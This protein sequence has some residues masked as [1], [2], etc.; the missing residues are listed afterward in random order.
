MADWYSNFQAIPDCSVWHSNLL[1]IVGPSGVGKS[2]IANTVINISKKFV[3]LTNHTTRPPRKTDN[4]EQFRYL[5]TSSFDQLLKH[6][7]F[8]LA[9]LA[10]QPHYGYG[11]NEL[12]TVISKDK[13]AILMFRHSGIK[14]L[15]SQK[16]KAPT[17]FLEGDPDFIATHSLNELKKQTP[18]DTKK[19]I[20]SNRLLQAEMRKMNWR[21]IVLKNTYSGNTELNDIAQLVIN[22][23]VKPQHSL[24]TDDASK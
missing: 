17:V 12:K 22:F 5:S 4:I 9:R 14:Y 7:Y 24:Q 16:L 1:I 23:M 8:F 2:S 19:V 20:Q 3:I 6:R 10:P 15:V 11:L 18:V 21:Y 13:F